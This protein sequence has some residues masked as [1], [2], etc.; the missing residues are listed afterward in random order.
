MIV[1]VEL[2]YLLGLAVK[3]L[4]LARGD[5]GFDSRRTFARRGVSVDTPWGRA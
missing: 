5:H 1:D 4:G 3:P 2:W